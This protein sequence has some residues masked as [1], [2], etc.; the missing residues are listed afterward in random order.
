MDHLSE[1]NDLPE[2]LV[3]SEKKKK[4]EVEHRK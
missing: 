4:K 2:N 3:C 1:E